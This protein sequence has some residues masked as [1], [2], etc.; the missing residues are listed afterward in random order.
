MNDT[1]LSMKAHIDKKDLE[2]FSQSLMQQTITLQIENQKLKEKLEHLESLLI[3]SNVPSIG[4]TI[5]GLLGG[6]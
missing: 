4:M 2:A 6:V 3:H 1:L 5:G